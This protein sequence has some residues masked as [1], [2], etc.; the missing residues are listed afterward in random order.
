MTKKFL[1]LPLLAASLVCAQ[2]PRGF[3]RAGASTVPTTPAQAAQNIVNRLTKALTLSTGQQSTI[4]G[5][6]TTALTNLQSNATTLQTDRTN[7][8]AAV[9][10]NNTGT[11]SS[12]LTAMSPLQEQQEVIRYNAAAAIYADLNSTQQATVN[13]VLSL[14]EGGGFGGPGM[15]RRGPPPA[16]GTTTTP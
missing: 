1:I 16:G 5:I 12:L 7:L 10:A 6:L 2:G 11:I 15:G 14:V 3:N 13:N 9:K 8:I 4:L